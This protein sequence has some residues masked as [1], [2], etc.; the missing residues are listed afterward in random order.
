MICLEKLNH[1]L[2]SAWKVNL[3]FGKMIRIRSDDS[4]RKTLSSEISTQGEWV[5]NC[6]QISTVST[7]SEASEIIL[8]CIQFP[9][10]DFFYGLSQFRHSPDDLRPLHSHGDRCLDQIL[11]FLKMDLTFHFHRS[12]HL[13]NSPSIPAVG[14]YCES[15]PN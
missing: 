15:S 12:A 14:Y 2:I 9:G 11:I 3:Q 8:R 13:E 5:F 6:S 7:F 10:L 4:G 1:S